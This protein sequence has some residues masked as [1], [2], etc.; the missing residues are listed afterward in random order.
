MKSYGCLYE[1]ASSVTEIA[2]KFGRR[3]G[4]ITSRLNRLGLDSDKFDDTVLVGNSNDFDD[5]LF[6]QLRAVR[7][8]FAREQK[9]SPFVVFNNA[10]LREIATSK[11]TDQQAML[12]V[13]GVGPAK[14]ERYGETFLAA[15]RDYL[16]GVGTKEKNRGE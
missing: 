14:V 7:L 2:A 4:A 9:V 16:S 13:S 11:P 15:I 5:G 8:Q 1:T 10:T 3:P 6:E 12:R